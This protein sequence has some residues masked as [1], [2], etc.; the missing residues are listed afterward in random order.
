MHAHMG[1]S[2]TW[3]PNHPYGHAWNN[4]FSEIQTSV[5]MVD[6]A[7][8]LDHTAARLLPTLHTH[9]TI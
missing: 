9:L 5:E 7:G 2:V 3:K 6:D 4:W 8:M 1:D